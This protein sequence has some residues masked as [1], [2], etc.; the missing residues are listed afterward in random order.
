MYDQINRK[1]Y[2]KEKY[3]CPNAIVKQLFH[4]TQIVPI[5]KIMTTGFLYP[6]RTFNGMD[7]GFSDM[8]DYVLFFSG[9]TNFNDRRQYNRS[10]FF[11]CF[12]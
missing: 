10:N 1:E 4:G 11:H 5:S 9:G 3:N 6:I 12:I 2:L 8:L 7:I